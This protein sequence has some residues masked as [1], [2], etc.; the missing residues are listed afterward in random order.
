MRKLWKKDPVWFAVAW[1]ILY[2][3]GFSVADGLSEA[4]GIPKLVTVLVGIIM[5][6]LLLCFVRKEQLWTRIG[7]C[8]VRGSVARLLWFVPLLLISCVNLCHGFSFEASPIE[9]ILFVLS[10]CLVAFLEE[11]IFRGFLFT[12]MCGGNVAVA[13]VVSSLTFG[14]GHV[15]NLLLGAPV[16]DTAL[17]LVYASAVGFCYTALF[18]T[19]GSILPCILSHTVVNATSFFAAE[20][21]PQAQLVTAV[22]QTVLAVGYGLWLLCRKKDCC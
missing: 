11:I 4:I 13:V 1:I 8:K 16:L 5:A 7:L 14:M 19:C 6:S 22:A 3:V 21:G 12:G 10:M 17:Q 20:T 15:V 18:Y 2:V 9:A